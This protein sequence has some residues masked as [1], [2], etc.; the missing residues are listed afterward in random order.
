MLHTDAAIA[1]IQSLKKVLPLNL[2]T[3]DFL[4]N[5][6]GWL[7]LMYMCSNAIESALSLQMTDGPQQSHDAR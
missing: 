7:N 4:N 5:I 3:E 2:K 1:T 6:H